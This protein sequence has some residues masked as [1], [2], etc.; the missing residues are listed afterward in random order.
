MDEIS[1]TVN[2]LG[3]LRMRDLFGISFFRK[4]PPIQKGKNEISFV[5]R[6]K[7]H[8]MN[9]ISFGCEKS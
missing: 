4:N 8:I 7:L 9:E 2:P 5:K 1:L 6:K 3:Q